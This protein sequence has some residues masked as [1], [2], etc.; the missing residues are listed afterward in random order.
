MGWAQ[1]ENGRDGGIV[2]VRTLQSLSI[3]ECRTCNSHGV[4]Y[5]HAMRV[6]QSYIE[7]WNW[8]AE[9]VG[10]FTVRLLQGVVRYYHLTAAVLGM[11]L[12]M[13]WLTRPAVTHVVIRQIYFTGVQGV[14]WM[15]F[16]ALGVG[17][18]AIYNIVVFAQQIQ[19]MSLIGTL[20]NWVLVQEM[21]PFMVSIFLLVR[22]GVA[23][24]TEI[25]YMHVR[26][27]DAFLRSMGVHPY[28]YLHLPRM[29]A[30]ALSGLILTFLFVVVSVW[31]GGLILSWSQTMNFFEYLIE[32]RR[33]AGIEMLLVMMVKGLCFPML[34]CMLLL[35]QACRVG[36]DPN[37]IPVRATN[38]V[39]GALILMIL[40][41]VLWVAI[42]SFL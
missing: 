7:G 20:M 36:R 30:F 29:I 6:L 24:V 4:A 42:R 31:V 8:R 9:R 13:Q 26:G 33:G 10:D 37:Q 5:K 23:I 41:D 39:L 2:V 27:E 38:G 25:G 14:P 1:A 22:S 35:D 19:D 3:Y 17:V 32:V 40:L 16:L 18:A 28:E 34:S 11:V 21:A 12:K 15:L